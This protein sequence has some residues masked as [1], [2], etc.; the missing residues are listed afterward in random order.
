[1]AVFL[2]SNLI[3]L[4]TGSAELNLASQSAN[5]TDQSTPSGQID[6][7]S[8]DENKIAP[9]AKIDPSGRFFEDE[10]IVKFKEG[11]PEQGRKGILEAL[12]A[13]VSREDKRSKSMLLKVNPSSREE[14]QEALKKNPNIEYVEP[15]YVIRTQDGFGG[16][17]GNSDTIRPNDYYYLAGHQWGL[18]MITALQ[19]WLISKGSS[20]VA[21]VILDSGVDYNHYDLGLSP[22]GRVVKGYDYWNLDP[23]PMDDNGHGTAVAG[24]VGA[25]TNNTSGIAA[26]DWK[27]R[28]IAI[29]THGSSAES[30]PF[31]LGQGIR[32][33]ADY[34]GLYDKVIINI[35]SSL[36]DY[37]QELKNAINYALNNN[38]VE[39]VVSV[40]NSLTKYCFMGFPAA[41]PG[42]ISV[43][44]VDQYYNL[45]SGCTG[46]T[47]DGTTYQ[48]LQLV[49]P[50]KD[51]FTLWKNSGIGYQP[52]P[53]S[54][55][56]G[57]TSMATPFVAGVASIV[58]TCSNS[59]KSAL[60]QGARDI[61]PVGWDSS[62]G[63]GLVNLW[64]SLSTACS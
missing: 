7:T 24:V 2:S 53:G 50:G 48:K 18:S 12:D 17:G 23:D 27:A 63:Y 3:L 25:K 21:V 45:I 49:A 35:S 4:S 22:S 57:S 32:D 64:N 26:V 30:N 11:F 51:I 8:D 16:G 61:G 56:P 15:S 54:S 58:S 6:Q 5:L 34:S 14:I 55:F 62:F 19:G 29:K 39:V 47:K 52:P 10:L 9:E 60:T 36:Q 40:Q 43:A 42:V 20:S 59:V 13:S 37:S 31:I 1:M 28:I 46:N 38:Q 33:A 41:F 44:A